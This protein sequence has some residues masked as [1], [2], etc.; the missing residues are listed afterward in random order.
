VD[1]SEVTKINISFDSE[2]SILNSAASTIRSAVELNNLSNY[3]AK[4]FPVYTSL[5][6]V[7]ESLIR[8][9]YPDY[10]RYILGAMAVARGVVIGGSYPDYKTGRAIVLEF[11]NRLE[12]IASQL[13]NKSFGRSKSSLDEIK[14]DR[15]SQDKESDLAFLFRIGLE[16]GIIFNVR[17]TQ[18]IFSS[19]FDLEKGD[20]AVVIT[21]GELKS[22]NIK[23]GTKG[24]FKAVKVSYHNPVKN[25]VVSY[26]ANAGD[27]PDSVGYEGLNPNDD[28]LNIHTKAEN[29]QQAETKGKVALHRANSASREGSITLIGNPL[30]VAGV[31]FELQD[32]GKLSG[33]YQITKSTHSITKGGGYE[34]SLDIKCVDKPASTGAGGTG[35][36]SGSGNGGTGTDGSQ[37]YGKK[38]ND[39]IYSSRDAANRRRTGKALKDVK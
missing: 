21:R 12:Q 7:A 31:N 33:K 18:L 5:V 4:A 28:T 32:M 37:V 3:R 1:G 9:G 15:V 14:I 8:K 25:E 35:G 16:Y 13:K 38:L 22:Y 29:S 20:A 23:D 19:M 17:D 27:D 2:R 10:G 39:N 36:G 34:V 6:D 24:T 26:E 30:L 11:V